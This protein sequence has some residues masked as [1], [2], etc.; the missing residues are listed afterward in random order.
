MSQLA[1]ETTFFLKDANQI[2]ISTN[3][4]QSF[5]KVSGLY[6][7]INKCELIA[8]KDCVKPSYYGIPVKEEL[9]VEVGS[10]HTLRLESLKVVFQPLHKFLVNNL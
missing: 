6:L 4:T 7:N 9:T 3:V 8:V 1:D 10:L 2:P 5:S